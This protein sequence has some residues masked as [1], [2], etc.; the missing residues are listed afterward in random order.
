MKEQIYEVYKK[1]ENLIS[2]NN[3][4]IIFKSNQE[5][6][7]RFNES[8]KE[9]FEIYRE[10]KKYDISKYL[11]PTWEKNMRDLE[12]IFFKGFNFSFLRIPIIMDTMFAAYQRTILK[13]RI[14]LLEK[15]Y[16][17]K[18]LNFFL[19]EDA[20]GDPIILNSKYMTSLNSILSLC[21]L[22]NFFSI[23]KRDLQDIKTITE[24]GG[25]YGNLAKIVNRKFNHLTYIII[26]IPLFSCLQWIYLTSIFG[27][28][29]VH[30]IKSKRDKI[31]R[32]KINL[33]SLP[34]I[35]KITET[36]LFIS[37]WALSESSDYSQQ[38]VIRKDWFKAK[39]FLIVFQKKE[40]R[41]KHSEDIKK[42]L[43][44]KGATIMKMRFISDGFYAIK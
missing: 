9:F 31:E 44:E 8:K 21:H 7:K 42:P 23:S 26:D 3:S 32:N 15:R 11:V 13:K 36:D 17:S 37:T 27:K 12:S 30:I 22:T 24:W 25:G 19:K 35:D 2:K 40:K 38:Y 4:R 6:L 34:F 43:L 10:L 41:F 5:Q 33:I 28:G 29:K 39:N 18:E 16:S 1:F 20:V 14:K